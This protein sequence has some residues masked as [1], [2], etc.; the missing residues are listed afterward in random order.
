MDLRSKLLMKLYF[1]GN[2]GCRGREYSEERPTQIWYLFPQSKHRRQDS[3]ISHH[4]QD[5]LARSELLGL[6]KSLACV[7]GTESEGESEV[8][9]DCLKSSPGVS[10]LSLAQILLLSSLSV[11]VS[12]VGQCSIFFYTLV[13]QDC[14]S[15]LETTVKVEAQPSAGSLT[16]KT[17]NQ[18]SNRRLTTCELVK[19]HVN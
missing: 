15:C 9:E 2:E 5:T 8:R 18:N 13:T 11:P 6:K 1:S 7:S 12:H 10:N 19:R 14:F 17:R 3:L 4:P 16:L